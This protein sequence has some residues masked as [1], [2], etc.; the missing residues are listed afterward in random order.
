[1]EIFIGQCVDGTVDRN[2]MSRPALACRL[3]DSVFVSNTYVFYGILMNLFNISFLLNRNPCGP[4]HC[5]FFRLN[6]FLTLNRS[7]E[8]MSPLSRSFDLVFE[9]SGLQTLICLLDYINLY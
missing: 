4:C 1:M 3:A 8:L 2:K 5:F 6:L 7:L 9:V